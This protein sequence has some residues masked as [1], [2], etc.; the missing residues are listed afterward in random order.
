M[1]RNLKEALGLTALIAAAILFL[2]LV[3]ALAPQLLGG[4]IGR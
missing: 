2:W 3:E 1:K 4:L